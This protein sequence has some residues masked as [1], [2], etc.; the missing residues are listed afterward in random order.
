MG[1]KRKDNANGS[2][3]PL[4][5]SEGAKGAVSLA[6][7]VEAQ[8]VRSRADFLLSSHNT[9]RATLSRHKVS[10]AEMLC[11]KRIDEEKWRMS[12]A[13]VCF[14]LLKNKVFFS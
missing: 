4:K 1:E 7:G 2:A 5:V 10:S 8:A 12:S 3:R 14:T 11:P 6:D 13:N 9:R